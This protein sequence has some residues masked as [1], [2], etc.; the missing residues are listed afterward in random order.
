[1]QQTTALNWATVMVEVETELE[2][3]MRAAIYMG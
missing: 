2:A 1:M 3:E